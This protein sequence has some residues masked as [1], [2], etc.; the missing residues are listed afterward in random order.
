VILVGG[1]M[2]MRT[3]DECKKWAIDDDR[4]VQVVVNDTG[5]FLR[6]TNGPGVSQKIALTHEA[7]AVLFAALHYEITGRYFDPK[8][9]K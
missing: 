8:D 2:T 7:T 4:E 6:F 9:A 3:G 5:T 1:G